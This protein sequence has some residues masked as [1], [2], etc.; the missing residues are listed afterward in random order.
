MAALKELDIWATGKYEHTVISVKGT[1]D[2]I[3]GK[4][5]EEG[6]ELCVQLK[7]EDSWLRGKDDDLHSLAGFITKGRDG[8]LEHKVFDVH[9]EYNENDQSTS[10]VCKVRNQPAKDFSF[11]TFN[12]DLPG[13]DEIYAL[14]SLKDNEGHVIHP[15]ERTATVTGRF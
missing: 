9:Y 5:Q 4:L 15:Q 14:V 1:I 12:E 13:I 8:K 3:S 10:F 7:G 2:W 6:A 11:R